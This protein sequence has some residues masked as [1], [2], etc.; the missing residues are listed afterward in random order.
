[1]DFIFGGAT[2]YFE[3]C[4]FFSKDVDR[5]VKG[6]VTA[7]STPEG[8]PFGYVMEGCRFRSNCPDRSVYLGRP[9][10][11]WGR[12]V[13]LRCV[14]GPHIKAEGWDDWGKELAHTTSFFAEYACT[15]PG[16][17]AFGAGTGSGAAALGAGTAHGLG[18]GAGAEADGDMDTK[19][20]RRPSD[21]GSSS[22]PAWCHSLDTRAAEAF[23]RENVLKGTDGWDPG[24]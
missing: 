9:W 6:Y 21:A 17:A 2:A 12:A 10:R 20:E 13:L 11:E 3:T 7:P 16:A 14:I 15:G 5:E 24:L 1:M 18:A 19:K 4:T 8:L 23:T 22:R